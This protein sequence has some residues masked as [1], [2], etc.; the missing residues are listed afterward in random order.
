M[1]LISGNDI[2]R[3]LRAKP[4]PSLSAVAR[5]LLVIFRECSSGLPVE[6]RHVGCP[7][8]VTDGRVLVCACSCHTPLF[9]EQPI[10]PILGSFLSTKSEEEAA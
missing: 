4:R 6:R 1:R 2:M 10:P 9:P 8:H 3:W 5:P 7:G